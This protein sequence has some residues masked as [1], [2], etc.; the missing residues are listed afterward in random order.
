MGKTAA[1][2]APANAARVSP[3][4]NHAALVAAINQI[5]G[6][7]VLVRR[8]TLTRDYVQQLIED[9]VAVEP[10]LCPEVERATRTKC[11]ELRADLIWHRDGAGEVVGYSSPV[12]SNSRRDVEAT[13]RTAA[14]SASDDSSVFS[15]GFS[16]IP[17]IGKKL[18]AVNPDIHARWLISE[19]SCMVNAMAEIASAGVET[20]ISSAQAWMLERNLWCVQA[21]LEAAEVRAELRS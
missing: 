20:P 18:Y 3:V 13:L 19:A 11:E 16:N 8:T 15:G 7:D 21:L 2:E 6:V 9:G 10:D 5:G 12:E 4:G 1:A 17:V 14:E